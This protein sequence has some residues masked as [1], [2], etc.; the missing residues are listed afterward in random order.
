MRFINAIYYYY[1]YFQIILLL[2]LLQSFSYITITVTILYHLL[3]L[4]KLFVTISKEITISYTAMIYFPYTFY[5]NRHHI[6]SILRPF[7]T[8]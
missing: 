6:I 3:L 7:N 8:N 1:Y 5:N 4:Q 2:L